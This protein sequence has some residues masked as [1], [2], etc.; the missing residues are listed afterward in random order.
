MELLSWIVTRRT[1]AFSRSTVFAALRGARGKAAAT[2]NAQSAFRADDE[3]FPE[4]TNGEAFAGGGKADLGRV[5]LRFCSDFGPF[6]P[7][8][9]RRCMQKGWSVCGRGAIQS[10]CGKQP[11]AAPGS[12][13]GGMVNCIS[14][15]LIL[16]QNL[17]FLISKYEKVRRDK[18]R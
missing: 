6:S 14:S 3:V 8:S 4:A 2:R 9:L 18:I 15:G 11:I 10:D 7:V 16:R 12:V 17:R 1:A 5:S 13:N